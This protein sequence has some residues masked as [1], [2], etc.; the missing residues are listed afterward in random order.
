MDIFHF[1][2]AVK[3]QSFYKLILSFLMEVAR[4]VQSIQN[5]KLVTFLQ[6][7]KKKNIDEIYFLHS[8][9]DQ[10]FHLKFWV[11][12]AKENFAQVG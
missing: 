1:L 3:Q 10:R 11:Y 5:R 4:H 6:Y 9:K 12:L 7:H 8:D 2:H